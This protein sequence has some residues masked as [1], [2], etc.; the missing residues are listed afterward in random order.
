MHV[1]QTAEP[2]PDPIAEILFLGARLN[3]TPEQRSRLAQLLRT[4]VD[5][6]RLEAMTFFHGVH[7]LLHVNLKSLPGGSIPADR[8]A[9]WQQRS[10][11]TGFRNLY[12]TR[13]LHVLLARLTGAGIP[14]IPFKGPVLAQEMY[15]NLSLRRFS[16][17]D[18]LVPRHEAVRAKDLLVADGYKPSL[19]VSGAW[20]SAYLRFQHHYKCVRPDGEIREIHWAVATRAFSFDL[21]FEEMW[22]SRRTITLTDR[23]V[24][25][26][27]PELMLLALCVHASSHCWDRLLLVCD[28]AALVTKHP[29][30][31]WSR[32]WQRASVAGCVRIVR[33]GLNLARNVL[34]AAL[35]EGLAA[36]LEGDPAL[37]R[38]AKN[39]VGRL[40]DPVPCFADTAAGGLFHLRMRERLRDR[41]AYLAYNDAVTPHVC[42]REFLQLPD[43][44]YPLYYAVKPLRLA[45]KPFFRRPAA[46]DAVRAGQASDQ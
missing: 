23:P 41:L 15:G 43:A 28:V 18:V 30:L 46:T 45:L 3:P 36:E 31:D 35:P 12:L 40:S 37:Q 33:L 7:T 5:W 16:D 29:Q 2:T 26:L 20:E 42:D 9:A 44:L 32:V 17:L 22:E 14:C 25:T 27:S 19:E 21:P 8:A 13:E 34:G 4:E 1:H 11:M 6:D 10:V 39:V 24:A 38:L